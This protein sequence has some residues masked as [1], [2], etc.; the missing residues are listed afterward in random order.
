MAWA[1]EVADK[2]ALQ[3]ALNAGGEITLAADIDAGAT[4]VTFTSGTATLN[5]GDFTLSS[6][7]AA[8]DETK[9]GTLF[10]SGGSLTVKGNGSITGASGNAIY[11][12][13]GSLIVKSGTISG[14]H[15][16]IF[17]EGGS[18]SI[19]SGI[20]NG[21][22]DNA[23]WSRGD[24]LTISGGVF[25]GG[26]GALQ[27]DNNIVLTITGGEFTGVDQDI[28]LNAWSSI[29]NP[30]PSC[31]ISGG[32]FNGNGIIKGAGSLV[33]SGGTF[34]VNPIAYL[35]LSSYIAQKVGNTYIVSEPAADVVAYNAS[36][37][38][39]YTSLSDAISAASAPDVIYM[40]K[41]DAT[42][43]SVSKSITIKTQG[44]ASN[45]TAGAGY[46]RVD[47]GQNIVFTDNALAAFLMS[48]G[49]ASYTISTN[50]N[51]ADVGAIHVHGNKTLTIN[52]GVIVTYKR[53]GDDA[54]IVVDN[55]ATLTIL[56]SGTFAP[57]I[58]TP[59]RTID[60]FTAETSSTASNHIGNRVIDVDG[61]LIVGMADDVDNCP[62]FRTS[63][64]SRGSAV[65]V[66]AS[67]VA[68]FHNADM[69][70][71]SVSIKNYGHV[72][73]NGGEYVSIA[74]SKNGINSNWYAYHLN[75]EGV[76][77]VN[78]GHF[79]GVQGAF[80]NVTENA[81]TTINNGVFE[82]VYG[83][84]WSDGIANS[85]PDPKST[86]YIDNYYALYVATH[87]VVNVYGGK[88]KVQTPSLGG[89]RVVLVGNNDAY[90][91][92]GIVN[93][94]GGLYQQKAYVTRQK[95]AQ[96]SFPASIPLT[97]QWYTAFQSKDAKNAYAPLPAGYE[98][99]E[100]TSG[101]DYEAGYRYQVVRTNDNVEE[102]ASNINLIDEDI[103]DGAVVVIGKDVE[104]K[105]EV[106]G[107]ETEVEVSQIVIN[108]GANLTVKEGATLT[109][110]EGGLN[111]GYGGT[112]TVEPGAVVTVADAGAITA[113]EENLI[114]ES[115]ETTQGAFLVA[116]AVEENTRPLATVK[117]VTKA[118]Q[119]GASE[120]V[121]ERFTIPTLN[122]EQT[123]FSIERM[124]TITTYGGAA[125]GQGLYGWDDATQDWVGLA[126]F[127]DM[128]PFKGYQLTNNS[129]YGNVVYTFK[130][131]LVGN[132][133]EDYTFAQSGFGFFGNSYTGDIDIEKFLSSFGSNMQK[134]IWI[135]DPY[136]DGFKSVTP[137]SYGSVKYGTR[138]DSHGLI[139]DVR[140]MQAFLMNTFAEG[141]S[142]T[143]VDYAN[144]IWGNPKYGLVASPAPAK[145]V[146]DNQDKVTVY[147]ATETQE[148]EV[149]FIRSSE[150]SIAFDNGADA[151]KWM[152]NGMNLYVITENGDLSAVASDKIADMTIAFR[153]GNETEYALG[154]DNI[155]GQEYAIRDILTGAVINMT[156][157]A[158]YTFTQE[159]NTM[160]PARFQIIG[161]SKVPTAVEDVDTFT[162]VMQK[163]MLNGTLYI[164][165]D[166]KWFT[167][168]GQMVK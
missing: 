91:T 22:D 84:N 138:R 47:M 71:A 2:D 27:A 55:G 116:P 64:L 135:Y 108:Q 5:L 155:V 126:R 102:V 105:V 76:M 14:A 167:V 118:K 70:V 38:I 31:S 147:V 13:N 23:I 127:K 161:S 3:V 79:V 136:T 24:A 21:S 20:I 113:T 26:W 94:Y 69:H 51:I 56:G 44:F 60:G 99:Q 40:Y 88:F 16:G 74:T 142:T 45:L 9:K 96:S 49:T 162:P 42:A 75:N 78:G 159:A 160:V 120:F 130:G 18:I 109:V 110:G 117:L 98:Y 97:S 157:N 150:Y 35:D 43:I 28:Y 61:T 54:N 114:I 168:Q 132:G 32:T 153:S 67:G 129:K 87:S 106:S 11:M 1:T 6:S 4:G 73:I 41:T 83:Y 53:Q 30:S 17:A 72:T 46:N 62:H 37:F 50:I 165:R 122:G 125:F 66:N 90:N 10:I 152:N 101:A 123:T 25:T 7:V 112:L 119:V 156:E 68:T 124:D 58:S 103:T 52:E 80:S 36:K 86:H 166:N 89:N 19:E 111:V 81:K 77:V 33:V 57:V 154:F 151:S 134:T 145:R 140:S 163:V 144:A 164:L 65:M 48:D 121:F 104:A 93:L 8:S 15:E 137:E 39:T 148:D 82:T 139:T 141:E 115:T 100:I 34:A 29:P 59:N 128:K 63:S 95:N 107:T 85:D 146:N 92:Y 158:T 133:N 149:S 143:Q 12:S 131:N